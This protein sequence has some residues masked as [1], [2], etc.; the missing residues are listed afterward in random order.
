ML[1]S[2]QKILVLVR[3]RIGFGSEITE[4]CGL[5]NQMLH[6]ITWFVHYAVEQIS[7][8]LE[9]IIYMHIA[10][11]GLFSCIVVLVTDTG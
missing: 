10:Y 9:F 7:L 8:H 4:T 3:F 2:F 11:S 5:Y 1:F 6:T